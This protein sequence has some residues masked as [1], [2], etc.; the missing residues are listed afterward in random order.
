MYF[1]FVL[2][3]LACSVLKWLFFTYRRILGIFACWKKKEELTKF[4]TLFWKIFYFLV[5]G[6]GGAERNRGE[7]GV[8]WSG[9]LPPTKKKSFF[10]EQRSKA[11]VNSFFFSKQAKILC[12]YFFEGYSKWHLWLNLAHVPCTSLAECPNNGISLCV[13]LHICVP[14]PENFFTECELEKWSLFR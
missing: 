14:N 1:L 6:R 8:E 13:G 7:A 11:W 5:G 4:W 9:A 12:S 3:F 2:T 10:P